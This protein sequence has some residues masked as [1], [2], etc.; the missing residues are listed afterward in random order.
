MIP[1]ARLLSDECI[2]NIAPPRGITEEELA[3]V[4]DSSSERLK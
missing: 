1:E 3:L 2:M 4:Y